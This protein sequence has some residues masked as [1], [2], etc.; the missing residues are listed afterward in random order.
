[1][2]GSFD[3]LDVS[4]FAGTDIAPKAATTPPP[5]GTPAPAPGANVP[6]ATSVKDPR[7]DQILTR[8]TTGVPSQL[9]KATIWEESRFDPNAKSYD[10]KHPLTEQDKKEGAKYHIVARG[11]G[12]VIPS[13]LETFNQLNRQNYS[14]EDLYEPEKNLIIVDWLYNFIK[15]TFKK[16]TS[17][18]QENWDDPEYVG[19]IMLAYGAGSGTQHGVVNIIRAME[20][21]GVPK[22]QINI[23]NI[24][25]AAMKAYPAVL[26]YNDGR[27]YM[28]D[29]G[30]LKN[31]KAKLK[32][33][34]ILRGMPTDHPAVQPVADPDDLSSMGPPAPANYTPNGPSGTSDYQK[35]LNGWKVAAGVAGGVA[36]LTAGHFVLA[37]MAPRP[38]Q[39]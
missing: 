27:G 8:I 29:P 34:L 20:A 28:S 39:A 3:D 9:L 24:R 7:F 6:K 23:D 32:D 25:T 31:I 5:A 2:G 35:P 4:A 30:L 38:V 37:G 15:N 17:T 1:M 18:Q 13:T 12:Q 26:T 10:K 36:L 33:Y 19:N 21:K 11:L 16:Y 22:E 14:F